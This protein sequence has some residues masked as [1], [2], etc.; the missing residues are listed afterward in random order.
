MKISPALLVFPLIVA[1]AT[2][3]VTAKSPIEKFD[4]GKGDPVF[5]DLLQPAAW[6][7]A[8]KPGEGK[9]IFKTTPQ[10]KIK[11]TPQ[12]RISAMLKN[13]RVVGKVF[14]RTQHGSTQ[15]T[16]HGG[17]AKPEVRHVGEM[18]RNA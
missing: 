12:N 7:R 8:L 4:A 5:E 1:A 16:K 17:I 14:S 2:Q 10:K 11:T 18:N 13:H 15:N 3:S 6:R 9:T